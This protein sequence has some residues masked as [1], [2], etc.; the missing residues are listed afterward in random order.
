MSY[1]TSKYILKN[2]LE[3]MI[4]SPFSSWWVRTIFTTMD[5]R[6]RGLI[7]G[8]LIYRLPL[9]QLERTVIITDD[10]FLLFITWKP[11]VYLKK[12]KRKQQSYSSG[13]FNNYVTVKSANL[14]HL[15]TGNFSSHSSKP[16]VSWINDH[17][18]HPFE[19]LWENGNRKKRSWNENDAPFLLSLL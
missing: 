11:P 9:S 1:S 8:G 12:E 15:T 2:C 18:S 6:S 4:K 3:I 17:P 19:K 13:W 10:F 16:P 14:T 7:Y 5:T